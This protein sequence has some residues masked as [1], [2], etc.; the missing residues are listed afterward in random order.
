VVAAG[1]GELLFREDWQESQPALPIDQGHVVHEDLVLSL[2]GP[3]MYGIKKSHHE[4]IENDPH[5]VWSGPCPGSWAVSLRHKSLLMDLSGSARVV[6]RTK[7]SGFRLLRLVIGF[8]D[9]TWL[10]SDIHDGVSADWRVF[11]IAVAKIRWRKLNIDRVTEAD[12][13]ESVDLTKVTE[14]G[15]TDLMPGGASAACSRIDWIEVYGQW[16]GTPQ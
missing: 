12:W 6:W 15:F 2:H 7:Q 4:W 3:G 13:A 1:D 10:V 9:G 8:Q 5:Y 16:G 14:I 11:E